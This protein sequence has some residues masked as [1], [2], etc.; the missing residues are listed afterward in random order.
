MPNTLSKPVF[1]A[2]EVWVDVLG[3]IRRIEL[4]RTISLTN[5]HIHQICWPRL[6]GDKV[7]V[8]EVRQIITITCRERFERGR[9]PK[10]LVQKD[11]KL[12]SLP[13]CPP[14]SYIAGFEDIIIE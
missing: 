14:P 12:M 9:P 10:A 8:H 7:A 5:R 2:T 4:A 13:S 6:H 3:F 1:L 11:G